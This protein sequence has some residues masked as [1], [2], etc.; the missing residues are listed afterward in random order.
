M[1]GAHLEMTPPGSSEGVFVSCLLNGV[2]CQALIDSGAQAKVVSESLFNH[3]RSSTTFVQ[4]QQKH[5]LGANNLPL[6]G[7][8]E[9]DV[10]IQLGGVTAQHR[11]YI[12]RGLAQELL[13]GIDFFKAHK[14]VLN[15]ES[16]TIST[17]K[18]ESNISFWSS[19]QV[20]RVQVAASVILPPNMVVDLMYLVRFDKLVG[21]K[22]WWECWSPRIGLGR[23]IQQECFALQ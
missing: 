23:Y 20:C 19:N 7:T 3:I 11:V 8:G 5:V 4:P 10:V 1:G 2:Q 12:C 21:W 13:I 9:A 14:C 17:N 18:G 16:A 22:I 6:D 15:F